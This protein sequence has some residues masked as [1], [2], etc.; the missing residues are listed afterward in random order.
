MSEMTVSD[1]IRLRGGPKA[2][3]DLAAARGRAICVS[4]VH[5]W[6]YSGI[7]EDHWPLFLALD[8][9]C[10]RVLYAANEKARM[11]SRVNECSRLAFAG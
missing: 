3:V 5:K 7:P 11:R 6:R 10:P 2:I 4:T 9:V 8:G 1:L